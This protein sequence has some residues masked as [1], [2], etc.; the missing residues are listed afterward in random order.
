MSKFYKISKIKNLINTVYAEESI[1]GRGTST[2]QGPESGLSLMHWKNKMKG[3]VAGVER[4]GDN[5]GRSGYQAESESCGV[6]WARI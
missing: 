1:P 6:L 3:S 4:T 2:F 5:D